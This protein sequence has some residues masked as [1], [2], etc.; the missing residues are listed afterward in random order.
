M[1]ARCCG[2]RASRRPARP[3]AR[4]THGHPLALA[5]LVDVLVQR[6]DRG[7]DDAG[8][9]LAD[10]PDLVRALLERFLEGVP[11]ARHRA[12]LEVCAH[13]RVTTEALLRDTL[14][15]EDAGALFAWPR[16]LSFVEGDAQ[17]L[18]PHDLARDVLDADLRWRDRAA[19][20]DLHGR[21]RRHVVARIRE[22]EG[23]A[24]QRASA[25]LHFLHRGNAGIRPLYDW[26]TLGR[27][28]AEGWFRSATRSARSTRSTARG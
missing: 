23:R 8:L 22:T 12:A 16:G 18:F 7:E 14:G 28:Y 11:S 1:P 6:G 25:D 27:T 2:P 26:D 13:T 4:I 5:L 20:A 24:Q 21:V 17:G 9:E 19:Y 3:G 15:S 10:A